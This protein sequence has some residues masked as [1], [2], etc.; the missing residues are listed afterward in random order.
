MVALN[1]AT[2]PLT[3]PV[4]AEKAPYKGLPRGGRKSK[5]SGRSYEQRFVRKYDQPDGPLDAKGKPLIHY[6][7]VPGSGAFVTLPG[8]V[9]AELVTL[10]LAFELKSWNKVNGR[11]EKTVTFSSSLLDKID[12]EAKQLNRVPLFVYHV[13]GESEEWAVVR[14]SWL[15]EKLRDYELQIRS[16][17]EQLE[18]AQL[19]A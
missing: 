14:Y 5:D 18:E 12:E 1:P 10:N 13:K 2:G 3:K 9:L 7:R 8:D 17:M 6:H 16:L 19:A 15:H 4:K 11:G